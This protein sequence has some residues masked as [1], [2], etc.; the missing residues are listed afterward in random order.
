MK[1]NFKAKITLESNIPLGV[2][3]TNIKSPGTANQSPNRSGIPVFA[4]RK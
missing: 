1:Q 4:A 2:Q 3:Q